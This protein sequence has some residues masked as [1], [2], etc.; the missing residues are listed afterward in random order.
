M[1]GIIGQGFV[2]NAVY[3]KFK[4]YYDVLTFDLDK[5][6]SNSNMNEII[7]KCENIFIC[8]PT[9]MDEDGS[10]NINIVK[11]VLS[12]ID[13]MVDNLETKR[14]IV[15][16]STVPPGTTEKW[17][18]RYESLNIVFNPEFLTERN[19][20]DDF[21]N[22]SRIILGGPRP[23]TT[24]LR[25]LYSKVFPKAH[26]IKTGSTHAEM[27][28]YVTNSFLAT[29]VS[30]ANEM[31]EIC[32]GI[33]LDYDKVI[34]YACYDDRLGTSHW[35]VPGPDGDFGY[36]GH[37]FPKDVKALIHLASDYDVSS[38][39]LNATDQKNNNVRKNRDWEQMKGRAVT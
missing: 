18:E 23:A 6:K 17:N 10:C 5:T 22:Q 26:I 14:N 39:M 21:N 4:N 9:P 2:G 28:K 11:G 29:K 31:Y 1:I 34:E 8:L 3:Q 16:K 13:L 38:V 30:F 20:V 12:E 37:C 19:A 33:G 35:N 24:E 7:Y 25:R 15:I 27:V 36:G 32:Q